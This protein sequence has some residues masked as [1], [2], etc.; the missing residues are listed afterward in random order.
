[1]NFKMIELPLSI[2]VYYTQRFD[3]KLVDMYTGGEF[4]HLHK[5][6]D[7]WIN[8]P[9]RKGQQ[10]SIAQAII[11]EMPESIG[12]LPLIPLFVLLSR[13]QLEVV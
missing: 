11:K 12:Q 6:N 5:E 8:M 7:C 4:C 13:L 1:M 2:H 9:T 10:T 3:L